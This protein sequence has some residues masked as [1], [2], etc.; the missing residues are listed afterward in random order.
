MV[1]GGN[2]VIGWIGLKTNKG[3]K[4]H[5]SEPLIN[6]AGF[7]ETLGRRIPQSSEEFECVCGRGDL[8]RLSHKEKF[9]K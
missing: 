6:G 3:M 9:P 2:S 8:R 1:L 7:R 5:T 4:R